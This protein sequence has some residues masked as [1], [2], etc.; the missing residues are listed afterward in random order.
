MKKVSIENE[1]LIALGEHLRKNKRYEKM[2][3]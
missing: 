2:D 1:R 3:M